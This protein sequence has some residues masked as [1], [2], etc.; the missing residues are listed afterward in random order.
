MPARRS[1]GRDKAAP[2]SVDIEAKKNSD[3]SFTGP[4]PNQLQKNCSQSAMVIRGLVSIWMKATK[5]GG[6]DTF[7]VL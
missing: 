5:E 3:I 7:L 4:L 2:L 6:T 1:S